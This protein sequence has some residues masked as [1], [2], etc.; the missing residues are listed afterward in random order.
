[1]DH[2]PKDLPREELLR[3]AD[4]AIMEFSGV[5]AQAEVHFKFTCEKCGARNT[6]ADANVLYEFGDCCQCNHRTAVKQGGFA[7]HIK[8][9]GQPL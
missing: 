4:R 2:I 1:M 9:G 8:V 7:L 5:G 6:F 3:Q